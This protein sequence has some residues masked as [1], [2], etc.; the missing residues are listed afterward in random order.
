[1]LFVGV[2]GII[3]PPRE[4]TPSNNIEAMIR[5]VEKYGKLYHEE[6]KLE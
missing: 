4:N 5:S 1:M 6:I 3:S 2:F